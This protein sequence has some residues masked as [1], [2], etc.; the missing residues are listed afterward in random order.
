MKMGFLLSGIVWGTFFII[1]GIS[2]ILKHTL[3]IDIPIVRLF[4]AFLLIYIGVKIITGG[5]FKDKKT[6]PNVVFEEAQVDVT[7]KSNEY[8]VIFGKGVIDLTDVAVKDKDVA[9]EANTV[10]GDSVIRIKSDV[11]TLIKASAA[12]AGARLPDGNTA[13][14]GTYVYKNKSF[15]EGQPCL[16]VRAN[17]VFGGL[18]V[19]EVE[20]KPAKKK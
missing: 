9:I 20:G 12:F 4:F 5:F 11:P 13:A 6:G 16:K 3:N 10:F 7:D 15:K 17:V 19:E 1:L 14:F 18:Q 2:I 8:N